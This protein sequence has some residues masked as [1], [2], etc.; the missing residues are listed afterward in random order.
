MTLS[1]AL[2]AV[3]TADNPDTLYDAHEA[4]YAAAKAVED[5]PNVVLCVRHP[6]AE[7]A[8]TTSSLLPLAVIDVDLGSS[9]DGYPRDA[10]E[11]ESAISIADS[12]TEAAAGLPDGDPVKEN[13]RSLADELLGYAE[14]LDVDI[15]EVREDNRRAEAAC[16]R[17]T[18]PH[19]D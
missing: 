2:R 4:L 16:R 8:F 9:F 13:V 18:G 17:T 19:P 12:I 11:A 7:N 1:E 5:G 10:E 6:D 15:E 3:E 14:E